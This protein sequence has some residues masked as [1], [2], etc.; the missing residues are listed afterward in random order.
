MLRA[1]LPPHLPVVDGATLTE[2]EL[3]VVD[4]HLRGYASLVRDGYV[5][6]L[7]APERPRLDAVAVQRPASPNPEGQQPRART[8]R[9]TA[10][11]GSARPGRKR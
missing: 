11:T 8:A 1:F 9:A 3:L 7:D 4:H 5:R 2:D 6:P 10:S